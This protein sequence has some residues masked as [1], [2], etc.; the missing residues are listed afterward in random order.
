MTKE[1]LHAAGVPVP[2]LHYSSAVKAKGFI[3]VSGQVAT[4]FENGLAPETAESIGLP[5]YAE[6]S[7]LR[8]TQFNLANIERLLEAGGSSMENGVWLNQSYPKREAVA[9]YHDVRRA[10][11]GSHIPPSTSIVQEELMVPDASMVTDMIAVVPGEMSPKEEHRGAEM[12]IPPGS[13]YVPAVS[14]GD[15]VFIAGQMASTEETE[16]APEARALP[17]VWNESQIQKET[18][19]TLQLV[20]NGLEAAGSSMAHVVKTQVY[21]KNVDVLPRMDEIWRE[22]FGEALPA[23][24]I[25]PTKEFGLPPGQIE[26]NAIGVTSGSTMPRQ[27]VVASGVPQLCAMEPHAVR[28]G[29]LVFLSTLLAADQ[30]GLASSAQVHP[31]MPYFGNQAEREMREILERASAICDAAGTTVDDVVRVQCHLIDLHD[32]DAVFRVMKEVWPTDPPAFTAVRV[33]APL[34]VPECR[35]QLDVTAVMP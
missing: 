3:F 9:P 35:I 10:V 22:T 1:I 28:A 33:P 7:A 27:A 6:D 30:N 20:R 26:I 34:A 31:Q 25:I 21:L 18:A 24:T 15:Y 2:T 5:Y 11:M 16:L 8:Q 32:L 14:A 13:N 23:R 29:D 4:D 12:L 17:N 19:Y